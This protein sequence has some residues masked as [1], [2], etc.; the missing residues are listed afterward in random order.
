MATGGAG[1]VSPAAVFWWD[2]G[3]GVTS[4][5]EFYKPQG[6][7]SSA[8]PGGAGYGEDCLY[9]NNFFVA[10]CRLT[11]GFGGGYTEV[12]LTQ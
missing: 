2:D 11:G 4:T 1:N 6:H 12:V 7:C 5:E 10:I 9:K 8:A 3:G